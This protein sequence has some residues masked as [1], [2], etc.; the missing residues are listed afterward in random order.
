[1]NSE[2]L[3]LGEW[4]QKLADMLGLNQSNEN[5]LN[6]QLRDGEKVPVEAVHE[7]KYPFY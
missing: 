3:T 7:S 2:V 6:R 5:L 1:M 4:I